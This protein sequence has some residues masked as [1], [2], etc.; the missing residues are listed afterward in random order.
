MASML[1]ER[2]PIANQMD[3]MWDLRHQDSGMCMV[4]TILVVEDNPALG[5]LLRE[6]L[7]DETSCQVC[8]VSSAEA[9][10]NTLQ[11]MKPQ[12]FVL[13]YCLPGMNGLELVEQVRTMEG[14]QQTPVLLMSAAFPQEKIA[15]QCLQC[16][17]KP[18]DLDQLL[19]TV[20]ELLTI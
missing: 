19:Q 13:D 16:L 11:M 18:F 4:K 6:I 12:L 8:L 7:Q 15:R 3:T 14:Y 9:A 10:L 2:Q 1:L 20:E 5:N 17:S